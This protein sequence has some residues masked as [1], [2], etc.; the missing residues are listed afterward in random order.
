MIQDFQVCVVSF[1]VLNEVLILI[2][3]FYKSFFYF[4]LNSVD[5]TPHILFNNQGEVVPTL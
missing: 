2:G 4:H 1:R 3:K 5:L